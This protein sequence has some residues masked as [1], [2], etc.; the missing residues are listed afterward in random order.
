M[1]LPVFLKQVD[2]Q[3]GQ[4]SEEEAAVFIHSVARM[5]PEERREDFL[6]LLRV[7]AGRGKDKTEGSAS[8][9]DGRGAAGSGEELS[10]DLSEDSR[11][12]NSSAKV[13]AGVEGNVPAKAAAC[14][15]I[16]EERLSGRILTVS[17]F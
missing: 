2:T 1:T 5:L 16:A 11:T 8:Y 17:T 14:W 10:K 13:A 15:N 7:Y 6:A 4:M 12:V 9:Y 3:C